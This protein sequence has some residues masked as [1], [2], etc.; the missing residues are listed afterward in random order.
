MKVTSLRYLDAKFNHPS[1]KIKKIP[2]N[3]NGRL[4]IPALAGLLVI[5][6]NGE[7]MQS[8][9]IAKSLEPLNGSVLYLAHDNYSPHGTIWYGLLNNRPSRFDTLHQCDR[10]T[11]THFIITID[12]AALYASA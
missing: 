9:Q 10:H 8:S 1:P 4:A 2:K 11:D 12:A 5:S 6:A 3:T 7:G